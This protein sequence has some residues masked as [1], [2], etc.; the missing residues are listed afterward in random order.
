M[1]QPQRQFVALRRV[2][3]LKLRVEMMGGIL[4]DGHI[5]TP[6]QA[7]RILSRLVGLT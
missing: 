6:A 1:V 3:L 7:C 4:W 2:R 5:G